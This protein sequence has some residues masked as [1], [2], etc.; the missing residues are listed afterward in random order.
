MGVRNY[1]EVFFEDLVRA[2]ERTLRELCSFI[3]LEWHPGMLR[4]YKEAGRRIGEL[5]HEVVIGGE[6]K[7]S[8][9]KRRAIFAQV[10][11]PP[12]A[13]R[14]CRW[15]RELSDA[16]HGVFLDKAGDMLEELGYPL[17]RSYRF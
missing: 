3:D 14:T 2:P 7:V 15:M 13:E 16:E 1:M 8:A 4:Y 5:D 12:N 9:E 6:V 11:S 10:S 17:E